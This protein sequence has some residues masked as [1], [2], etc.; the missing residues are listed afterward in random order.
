M[1]GGKLFKKISNTDHISEWKS[2]GLSEFI[3]RPAKE[4][5]SP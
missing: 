2:Q 1:S 5:N 4:D 3:K